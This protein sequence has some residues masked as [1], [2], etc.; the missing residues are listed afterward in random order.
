MNKIKN[1]LRRDC[2]VWED[3]RLISG[4]GYASTENMAGSSFVT[5]GDPQNNCNLLRD[6]FLLSDKD[7]ILNQYVETILGNFSENLQRSLSYRVRKRTMFCNE[8]IWCM[9][10]QIIGNMLF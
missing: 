6:S 9:K 1:I 3:C 8:K 2:W 4:V 10:Y 7:S 5:H